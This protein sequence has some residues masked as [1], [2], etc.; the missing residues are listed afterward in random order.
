MKM[1]SVA[2]VVGV[3]VFGAVWWITAN[4]STPDAA[5]VGAGPAYVQ[6]DQG[7]GGVEIEVT[8]A[9]PEYVGSVNTDAAKYEPDS[10]AVFL[11]A[12][13]THSVDLSGYDLVKISQLRAGG[14]TH[15]AL[16]WISTSDDSHH[17]A[18]V[19]LFPQVD[20]SQAV[21]LIITTIAGVP[22]R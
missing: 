16:R 1:L 17:R 22:A 12:M 9:T 7:Q 13:N 15:A 2:L 4:R 19:L 20:P 14:E 11:V 18:G 5:A 3:I 8:Y 10:Y 21:E 6:R